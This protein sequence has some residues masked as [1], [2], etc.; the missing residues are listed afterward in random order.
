MKDMMLRMEKD[1][2]EIVSSKAEEQHRS[3]A[4]KKIYGSTTIR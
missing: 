4:E 1:M 2:Y 3:V